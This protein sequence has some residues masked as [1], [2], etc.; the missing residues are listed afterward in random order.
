MRFNSL[1]LRL[2]LSATVWA[3]TILL[4]TGIVLSSL[5]RQTV[6]R[7][8]DRRL[9]VYL[10]TLVADVASP[11]DDR[12][13]QALGEPLFELPLS[14]WYWQVTRLDSGKP[15]LRASRSLWDGGLPHLEA[16]G[17]AAAPDGS[18]QGYVTGP[19][20]QRLRLVERNIDLGEEGQYL[21][22]VAG[23]AAEITDDV[24]AFDRALLAT[25]S[26]LAA[27]L[28]LTTMFQVRFG[29][30]PLKRITD[31]LAAIRSGNAERLAG[32]FP[33]EIAPLARETNALIEANKGIVERARTHVGNLAHALK[34][35]LSVMVNEAAARPGD[36]LAD[37][38]QEQAAIMRDQVARHLE[39]ARIAAR[40]TVVGSVTEVLPV[41]EALARTME[42]IHRG[43][44]IAIEVRTENSGAPDAIRFRGER[45]DLE[46]MLGN[47]IDN[48][49]KWA[50]SRVAIEV[51]REGAG[52]AQRVR[53]VVD[54]DGPGL[55]PAEREQVARRGRRLDES[56]PGSGLGL[57][58][59]VELA[60][61]YGGEL[62]L[63]SA[64][65]GGL[66]AELT[67]PAG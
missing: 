54:D 31:S 57:S 66:R 11:A 12:F 9:G 40:V 58:I 35:P 15:D 53:V 32:D 21:V 28:L 23:D 33:V 13:P 18:R 48:A 50:A 8:F 24:R 41:V 16:K 51:M 25:F 63:G 61:L 45:A 49:C 36:P 55:T 60:G 3:V 44:G 38:V 37:K 46:E 19:E 2:F 17:V 62:K 64:P 14:G 59:V 34:T 65:I 29:L 56:K 52:E 26:I 67:L 6:E 5:Y 1:A 30:A 20:D 4:V 7:S 10:R 27:V 43:R 22:A 42:K 47:L 39:R